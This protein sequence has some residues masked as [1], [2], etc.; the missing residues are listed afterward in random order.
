MASKVFEKTSGEYDE[1]RQVIEEA[2]EQVRL[3][4]NRKHTLRSEQDTRKRKENELLAEFNHK[5]VIFNELVKGSEANE[6][7]RDAV[8]KAINDG[9]QR[10]ISCREEVRAL[11]REIEHLSKGVLRSPRRIQREVDSLRDM[12]KQLRES[13]DAE[14]QRI[15]D[16]ADSILTI[17][18]ASKLLDERFTELERL[19]E[20][21]VSESY[22][23]LR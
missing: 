12:S 3:A 13:C 11:Q 10:I 2:Q 7:R 19:R 5:N 1:A 6:S 17:E 20:A 22:S 16:N 21:V 18:K 9:K 15:H 8:L 23:S 4:E 14:R